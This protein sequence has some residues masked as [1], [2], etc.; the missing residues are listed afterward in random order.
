MGNYF[1]VTDQKVTAAEIAM[2]IY[3]TLNIILEIIMSYFASNKDGKLVE[4]KD[5]DTICKNL[6]DTYEVLEG[7]VEYYKKKFEEYNK[8]SEIQKYKDKV[9]KLYSH[10]LLLM[11]DKEAEA[12]RDFRSRH[13]EKCALP[14]NSKSAGSTYIY[15]LTGTG[16]GTII[17]IT[18]PICGQSEDITDIDSW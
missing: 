1:T 17:K 18:C 4:I 14:L 6:R 5:I 15:E 9:D 3:A 12:E 13:Y 7:Q 8:D 16:L 10:S 2:R 11:S